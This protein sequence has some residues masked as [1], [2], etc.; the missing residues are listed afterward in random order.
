MSN[1]QSVEVGL[2]LP[3]PFKDLEPFAQVWALPTEAE[4]S[5]QRIRSSFQE[6][7]AFHDALLSRVETIFKYLDQYQLDALPEDAKRLM[8]LTLSLA[9]IAPSVHFYKGERQAH[10]LDSSRLV[11]WDV[12]HMTP[13][14]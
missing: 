1:Q 10:V 8:L 12:P 3:E 4:R 2:L 5:G 9:E 13:T 14:Y 6:L 11:R 7:T